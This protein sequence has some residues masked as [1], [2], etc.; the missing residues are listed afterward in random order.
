MFRWKDYER[1]KGVYKLPSAHEKLCEA[2]VKYNINL[3]PIIYGNNKLYDGTESGFIS[4]ESMTQFL[5]FV[6]KILDEEK[7]KTIGHDKLLCSGTIDAV[8]KQIVNL[9]QLRD[10][11]DFDRSLMQV[12]YN[13]SK[14][15]PALNDKI[16]AIKNGS[17]I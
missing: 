1:A 8:K 2:A 3:L 17:N 15:L 14:E 9:S 6:N 16:E 10:A 12:I 7:I 11:L 5:E 4:K 13:L